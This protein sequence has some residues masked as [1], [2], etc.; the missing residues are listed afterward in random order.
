MAKK[1][2][3]RKLYRSKTNRVIAGICGGIGEYF[4]IDPVI[5]RILWVLFTLA[6]GSGIIAYIIAW[7]IIPEE[8]DKSIAEKFS[9]AEKNGKHYKM[10]KNEKAKILM[11]LGIFIIIVGL[12]FVLRNVFSNWFG[13]FNLGGFFLPGVI[14]VIG[15]ILVIKGRD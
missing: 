4:N 14:I 2:H 15:I 10:E 1:Q 8:K 3:M 13:F 5:I 11:L 6:G 7:V 9:N 12:G